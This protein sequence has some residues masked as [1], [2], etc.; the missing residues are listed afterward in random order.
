MRR[1]FLFLLIGLFVSPAVLGASFNNPTSNWQANQPTFDKLY[2][3]DFE[4]YWPIL[5]EMRDGNCDATTDFVIGIPPGGCSPMVVTSDLLAEQNVP[6]FCQLYAIKVNPLIKVS[7]IKSISF[8]GDYPEGVRSIVYHPARAAV[9]SYNTLLG[10]STLENV[11]YVVII[12]NQNRV[13]EN[14]T[15]WIS[16]NLTAT[17]KYDAEEAYGVG[18][19]DYYLE[20]TSDDEWNSHY[21]ENA[22]WRGRGF[23]RVLDV[24]DGQAKI[25]VMENR[26]NVLRTLTLK[27]GETSSSSFLPGFYCK[28]GLK[29]KLTDIVTQEKMARLNVD[30]EDI[31]VRQGSKFLD[32]K[33]S[34]RSLD[35]RGNN[36]GDISIS[37]SGAG[38][39][40]PLSLKA[41]SEDSTL[42]DTGNTN[43][44]FDKSVDVVEDELVAFYGS[45]RKEIGGTWA[46][47]SLYEEIVLAGEIGK[48]ATQKRLLDL[49]LEEYPLAKTAPYVREMRARLDNT[50]YTESFVSVYV[51]DEF[52]SISVVDFKPADEGE[53]SVD[54]K[55][56]VKKINGLGEGNKTN[57]ENDVIEVERISVGK[58]S[59]RL[60]SEDKGVK[61]KTVWV[62]EGESVGFNGRSIYVSNVNVKQIAHVS[63][64]PDVKH[65]KSEAD[66]SFSIAVEERAI[67]L[68]PE[69]A[70][71]MI[72]NLDAT[73]D[74]WEGIVERL[75]DV[76]TGL[77][78]AC[79]ATS[80]VLMIKN[81]ADGASG[82]ALAR[83]KVM[84][85]YKKICDTEHPDKSR[86]ACY[87]E[88]SDEID[89]DVVAMTAVLTGVN[90]VMEGVQ[91]SNT[92]DT[93]SLFGGKG[94]EDN[95]KYLEDLKAQISSDSIDVMVGGKV[96][97]VPKSELYSVSQVRA[98]LTWEAAQ[99]GVSASRESVVAVAKVDMD[100]ALR[101][102]ALSVDAGIVNANAVQE[103]ASAGFSG[104]K[105]QSYVSADAVL[106]RWDGQTE[107]NNRI[108]YLNYNGRTYKLILSGTGNL[109]VAEAQLFGGGLWSEVAKPR[110]FD[111]LVFSGSG[112]GGSCVYSWT[113]D[114]EISYYESGKNK[115]LPAIVPFDLDNGWYAMVP[116]AGG[117][118]L[119][120]TPQGYTASADVRYFKICNVGPNGLMQNC[121]GDDLVQSFDANTADVVKTFGGCDVDTGKLYDKAREAIRSASQQYG[122]SRVNIFDELIEVGRPMSSVGGFECQD[123]MSPEDCK[124]MFNVCDPVICPPSRCDLGG[125]FPVSDVIQTGI[126]GSLTLCLPN[127]DDGILIP[128]CLSG[129]HA[130]LDAYVSIL[131]SEKD[132]LETSLENGEL[133]G[134]CDQI[135]SVYKCEFFWRQMSPLLDQLVPGVL[136][137]ASGG[138]GVRGGG[139]YA[140]APQAWNTM[141]QSVSFFKDTYAQNSLRAFNLRSTQEIGSQ[142][143]KAFVG[144]S[145]PG[146]ASFI[147]DLLAPESPVQFYA[148]FSENTFSE[149]TVP[150]TGQYK[151]YYH[152]YAGNDQGVQYKIYLKNPP[153]T[154]YYATNPEVAVKS[155]YIA[156][157]SS[158]DESIDFTAPSGYKELCVVINAQEECGFKSVTSSFG[159]DL[160]SKK[161]VEEQAV[162]EDI[163]TEKECVSGNPSA[164]S[165]ASLNLAAGADEVINPEIAMRGIVRICASSNP[166]TGVSSKNVVTCFDDNNCGTGFKC[167][168]G[169]CIDKAGSG[170]IQTS[171][172]KWK[173][174][175]HCGDINL[176]CWLDVDS[177]KDDL[178]ALEVIDGASISLLDER[179]GLI[180][181]T[182]L[183][184]EGVAKLLSRARENIKGLGVRPVGLEK[185]LKIVGELDRV[186]GNDSTAGA[187]TNGDRAEALALKASVYR[188]LVGDIV[189]ASVEKGTVARPSNELEDDV[190]IEVEEVEV[191]PEVAAEIKTI[192][193]YIEE[194]EGKDAFVYEIDEK[195][196]IGIGHKITAEDRVIF[197]DLFG[198]NDAC[199]DEMIAGERSLTDTQIKELFDRDINIYIDRTVRLF[200]AYDSYPIYVKMALVS[201]VYRGEMEA[202]HKTVSLIN[203]GDWQKAA[204][205]YVNREDYREAEAKGLGGIVTRMDKNR[206]SFLR[207]AS[208]LEGQ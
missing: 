142:V 11:G 50:D 107:G 146:S 22:F 90:G 101:N 87:N 99:S 134:I 52:K 197:S 28:A 80:A 135:T 75:G 46:E 139:E 82:E 57:I 204:A 162:D 97:P 137:F 115:G 128:V 43:T 176:R 199:F 84:G 18:K 206:D 154:S 168:D 86:T 175:G 202:G 123:F 16:G 118:F 85:E 37:C 78:G 83:T 66:F 127:A 103:L 120:D 151:V 38:R 21:M 184:L 190:R 143:C 116:N 187:G 94:I 29:I 163:Q 149:A 59:L 207:Y 53:K 191:T 136:D 195:K 106:L 95:K 58:V 49:F 61:T 147:E 198:C 159:L 39:I 145:V 170:T 144:T 65:E 79:F 181:N 26:D 152:I 153:A 35:V 20:P 23:L 31:W 165:L 173:D 161:Y 105:V 117:T 92:G 19:G 183:G 25:Q 179:R 132:C 73:I 74:K 27:T 205:E 203:A 62:N 15:K 17:M 2:S 47:E 98:V 6:V 70:E 169:K 167:G 119:D 81:M 55:I 155:G 108:Q 196:H 158:A 172:G 60:T 150:A 133:V 114:A 174:V 180:D 121:A 140:L 125:K 67:E 7:S 45:E 48:F 33:C 129:V 171:V 4:N 109:G 126:I 40:E 51:G 10:D 141:R 88:L 3:G 182:R 208:E 122:E 110:A 32:G 148:Q 8:K 186:I 185:A 100:D 164:L 96:V 72:E 42:A 104:A 160:L 130:G 68:S 71:K 69:R 156:A 113:G 44:Y 102:V 201:S 14:M 194:E 63:L 1:V 200:P 93:Q 13:E 41:K 30:G 189:R 64:I 24:G 192:K 5:N 56:G 131:K 188:L 177:V 76:V 54:L 166:E 77:K 91:E 138:K 36:D 112:D 12:L 193:D 124:L 111:S 9:K 178:E 157:G 89:T 34:V